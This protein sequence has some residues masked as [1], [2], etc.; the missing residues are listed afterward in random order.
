MK[1]FLDK[2][3]TPHWLTA[4][5]A[6]VVIFRI[7]NLFEPY[8]YG[9][10]MIYL[11]LG[12]AIRN[13]LTLYKDIHDNKP[14]LLYILAAIA[15][16]LFWFKV[17]L[18]FGSIIAIFLFWKLSQKLFKEHNSSRT[19]EKLII[20]ST[21][22]FAILTTLPL[23]EGNIA[24]AENFM[25]IPT[26]A[27][28][29]LLFSN[30][31]TIKKV[32]L[33]GA[34]FAL[35]VL[36]KVPAIFDMAGI[37]MFWLITS[38]KQSFSKNFKRIFLTGIFFLIPILLTFAWY[39]FKGALPDYLRAAYLQNFGYLSSFSGAA[40]TG[41]FF[42]RNLPLI[43]RGVIVLLGSGILFIYRKKI[44]KTFL[45]A[46][47]LL[48]FELF[49]VTL[50]GRPYPHYLLQATPAISILVAFLL[51]SK[52]LE[53]VLAIIPLF[54]ALVVPVYFKF[55]YY[56]TG[57]YYLRF[58]N[59][60]TK[61]I[62][63]EEYFAKFDSGIQSTYQISAFLDKTTLPTDRIFAWGDSAPIYALSRRLPSIKY[64]AAYHIY[65]FSSL[66]ATI[67]EIYQKPPHWIIILGDSDPFQ[68]LH[69]FVSKNY[70][71][72][73]N[74]NNNEIWMKKNF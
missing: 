10:E 66:D 47:V 55:Y 38:N 32:I 25:I 64:T 59:F 4:L 8:Y 62:S 58:I 17:F 42:S 70:I 23:L 74:E 22:T 61:R 65:D 43:I 3:H 46:C 30:T 67:N 45:F 72:V 68:S 35:A 12:N 44:D 28:F 37:F 16:N 69:Q 40:K 48:L 33:G 29:V 57:A 24:N 53:Q 27:A 18:M 51:A 1:N 39:Y 36:F 7:P 19:R 63:K 31:T 26:L 56:Q 21:I 5:F 49:A 34:M 54:L 52:N 41:T 50:S 14:P 2:I 60:A 15:G 13:G 20:I 9:D 73:S 71:L 6:L 11:T